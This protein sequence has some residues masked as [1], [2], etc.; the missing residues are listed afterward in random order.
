VPPEADVDGF[1]RF[2][3]KGA[4][5]LKWPNTAHIK[6]M[7]DMQDAIL[8]TFALRWWMVV[9]RR[10]APF[11]ITSDNPVALNWGEDAPVP[12]P[13]F[14]SPGFGR[15][16]TEIT[17]PVSRHVALVGTFERPPSF[18][19]EAAPELVASINTRTI[20]AASTLLAGPVPEIAWLH[21]E[22][23]P[24]QIMTAEDLALFLQGLAENRARLR[25]QEVERLKRLLPL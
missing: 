11:F 12:F 10:T 6:R 5:K 16:H 3:K 8:Q 23:T 18:H 22:R 2:V 15:R 24:R 9:V 14:E 20:L 25:K 17:F 1:C 13:P 21:P 19:L 7:I 4:F